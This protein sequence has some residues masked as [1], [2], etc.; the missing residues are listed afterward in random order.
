M[1]WLILVAAGVAAAAAIARL[2]DREPRYAYGRWWSGD[3]EM[4]RIVS[5]IDG[6]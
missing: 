2:R 5:I 6:P 1:R 4:P 3:L